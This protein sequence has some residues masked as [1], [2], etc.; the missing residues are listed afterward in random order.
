[1]RS[2]SLR[3]SCSLTC[4][5]ARSNAGERGTDVKKYVVSKTSNTNLLLAYDDLV[6]CSDLTE[7]ALEAETSTLESGE[8]H[9]VFEVNI[10]AIKG[11]RQTRSVEGY[12]MGHDSAD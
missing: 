2:L 4:W 9:F 3:V 7:A 10:K 6:V 5:P 12:R 1:M 8:N 11:F